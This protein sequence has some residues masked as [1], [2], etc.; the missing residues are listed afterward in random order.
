[1]EL[2]GKVLSFSFII[3]HNFYFR[4]LEVKSIFC[5]MSYS[6]IFILQKEE[7]GVPA[8]LLLC[9]DALS[10]TTTALGGKCFRESLNQL[11]KVAQS[12]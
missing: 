10:I 8:D 3:S 6:C 5:S 9:M 4:A 7:I 1:M 12:M 2:S 11:K